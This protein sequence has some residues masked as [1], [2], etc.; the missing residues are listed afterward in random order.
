MA[1]DIKGMIGSVSIGG[2]DDKLELI[3]AEHRGTFKSDGKVIVLFDKAAFKDLRDQ[4]GIQDPS[5][6]SGKLVRRR[7]DII[8]R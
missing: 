7:I 2:Y 4:L 5:I 6:V 3:I 1:M 8:I